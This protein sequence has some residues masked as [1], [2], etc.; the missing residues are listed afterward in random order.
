MPMA[1]GWTTLST[2]LSGYRRPRR[3]RLRPLRGGRA[4]GVRRRRLRLGQRLPVGLGA[5]SLWPVGAH[6]RAGLG[7]DPRACLRRRM[8]HVAYRHFRRVWI[9]RLGSDAAALDLAE[10]DRGGRGR[11]AAGPLPIL[12]APRDLRTARL[13]TDCSRGVGRRD[14]APNPGLRSSPGIRDRGPRRRATCCRGTTAL[15]ASDRSVPRRSAD[16]TGS[17]D[18]HGSPL[19]RAVDG[20]SARRSCSGP[21]NSSSEASATLR[22]AISSGGCSTAAAIARAKA[23]A[24]TTSRHSVATRSSACSNAC[25]ASAST[26]A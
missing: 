26:S 5:L 16:A 4:L 14:R 13:G 20:S 17:R 3:S 1:P 25:P 2:E 10:S 23:T 6:R 15:G 24:P 19:L 22:L 18:L 21:S 7:M 8:G 12:P 11:R 9:R